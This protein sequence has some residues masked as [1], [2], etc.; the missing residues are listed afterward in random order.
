[1]EAEGR[2]ARAGPRL[3]ERAELR[4]HLRA[5]LHRRP[6]LLRVPAGARD[7]LPDLPDRD[8][9]GRVDRLG[10]LGDA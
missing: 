3:A 5:V 10:A 6:L 2:R 7:L 4:A 1:M 8:D 9:R